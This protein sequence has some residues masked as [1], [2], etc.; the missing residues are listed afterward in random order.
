MVSVERIKQFINIPSEASWEIKDSVPSPSWPTQ[1]NI[2]I[3]D[4]QVYLDYCCLL[5]NSN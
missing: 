5:F 1:G 2:D 4:L 3:W